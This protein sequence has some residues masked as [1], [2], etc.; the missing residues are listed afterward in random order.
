MTFLDDLPFLT[1]MLMYFAGFGAAYIVMALAA[2]WKRWRKG[3]PLWKQPEGLDLLEKLVF[4]VWLALVLSTTEQR[5]WSWL[6]FILVHAAI[7]AALLIVVIPLSKR[8]LKRMQQGS[9]PNP[10]ATAE[11]GT[12]TR[13]PVDWETER[14]RAA[15]L[16]PAFAIYICAIFAILWGG[17]AAGWP[18]EL[19]AGLALA[20]MTGIPLVVAFIRWPGRITQSHTVVI[21]ASPEKVWD[22][23]HCRQTDSYYRET[24]LRIEKVPGSENRYIWHH[25]DLGYC[26]CCGLPKSR[27]HTMLRTHAEVVD[28]V[29]GRSERLV[30]TFLEGTPFHRRYY[31]SEENSFQIL[32]HRDGAEVKYVL[33]TVG[34]RIWLLAVF[35]ADSIPRALLADLKS[36]LEGTEGSGV[37]ANGRRQ[38]EFAQAS[39]KLCGCSG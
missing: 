30:S 33:S 2:G 23:L 34:V 10:N 26:G 14:R 39:P 9:L 32:P 5:S 36:Y 8:H 18:V 24:C 22:T 27:A 31:R 7:V 12:P 13:P 38:I 4:A 15:V 6:Q 16:L 1:T 28:L 19:R 35:A 11:T 29:P 3:E 25:A 21:A 37:F 17:K 20:W